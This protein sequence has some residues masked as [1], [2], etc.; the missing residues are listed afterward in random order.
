MEGIKKNFSGKYFYLNN[1]Y[2]NIIIE[3]SKNIPIEYYNE[4]DKLKTTYVFKNRTKIIYI[5]SVKI[6]NIVK[7]KEK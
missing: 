4:N 7:E 1:E 6:G 5:I 3:K 2:K